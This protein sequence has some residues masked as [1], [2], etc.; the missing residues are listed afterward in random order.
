[1]VHIAVEQPT[2][3]KLPLSSRMS[4]WFRASA[5]GALASW[6]AAISLI[7]SLWHK[8]EKFGT[9]KI[10]VHSWFYFATG[11]VPAPWACKPRDSL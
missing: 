11:S 8:C 3:A 9:H 5:S 10:R 2:F 6:F 1:M 7:S 4:S